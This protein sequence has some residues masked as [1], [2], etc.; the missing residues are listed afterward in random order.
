[1]SLDESG[2]VVERRPDRVMTDGKRMV[3]V[4]FKFGAPRAE[5]HF[6]VAEYMRLLVSMGHDDVKGYIWYVY[7]NII[8]EV[9]EKA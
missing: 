5:H 9:K 2:R 3:V 6:Q 7:N 8:E 4:D 1:M